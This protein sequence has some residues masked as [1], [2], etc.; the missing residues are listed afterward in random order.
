M[1]EGGSDI[2]APCEV[3]MNVT[4]E[5]EGLGSDDSLDEGIV[6]V[7]VLLGIES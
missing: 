7:M 3:A 4:S 1:V 2:E 5:S 6:E